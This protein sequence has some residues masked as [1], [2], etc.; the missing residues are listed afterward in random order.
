MKDWAV[1][2]APLPDINTDYNM[3]VDAEG[4]W[5]FS[6]TLSQDEIDV[7]STIQVG[8]PLFGDTCRDY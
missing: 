3:S 2:P 7:C 1:P 8:F 4:K 6:V 5:D